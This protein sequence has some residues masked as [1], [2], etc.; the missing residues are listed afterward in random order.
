MKVIKIHHPLDESRV[1]P[2]PIV[3]AMGFFDGVH[4]GHQQVLKVARAKA[5]E[6]GVKL[7]AITYDHHPGIVYHQLTKA[8]TQYITPFDR[9]M[10]LLEAQGVD[11]VY[12]VN[13][14][15]QFSALTPQEFV[16]QYLVKLG[17]R[18]VVAGFDHTYGAPGTDADMTH[19]ADY[20][21]GRFEVETVGEQ[22]ADG[23][24]ISSSS[25]REALDKGDIESVNDLLGYAFETQGVVVH[26]L[27]R[28]RTI[29]FPTINIV[30]PSDQWLP[31][32]G[33]Y[34]TEVKVGDT[35]LPGMASIGRNV[36]FGDN[37]P[38]TVEIYLLD[39]KGNLYGEDV[40]VRWHTRLRGEQKFTG[41]DALVEQ[42][43]K[44]EVQTRAFFKI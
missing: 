33:I 43:N 9:R 35:W 1:E 42:L 41:A 11:L 27:A 21:T 39:F 26:G 17:P 23:Q 37:N 28:G 24:K 14:T 44:D 3:L 29:G 8:D 34:T 31:G 10:A 40:T 38:V 6:L 32:I 13:F 2:G 4:K 19:L 36:T 15:G 16:N 7:A 30:H 12:L 20:A 5:D 22:D 18:V 25:I